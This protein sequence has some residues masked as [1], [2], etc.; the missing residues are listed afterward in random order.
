MKKIFLPIIA[1]A[2]LASCNSSP[3]ET[4]E[5]S[6][7]QETAQV[8]G[9][10][11]NVDKEA[12]VVSFLGTKPVGIHTGDFKLT[13]GVLSVADGNV[14]SGT[15]TIDINSLVLTDENPYAAK[16]KEHLLSADFFDASKFGTAKFEIT[17]CEVLTNDTTGTHKISGNLTMKERTQNV[18]FPA[19]ITLS[20]TELTATAKFSIDRTKWGLV[21]GNDKS[22]GDKFIYPVVEITLNINAKK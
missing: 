22:L 10:T 18:S 21:Y 19:K 11:Y 8:S 13:E 1:A 7:A 4:A 9:A 15:F 3:K 12:S 20:D 16:L 5:T 6:E 14:T 2:L 17:G